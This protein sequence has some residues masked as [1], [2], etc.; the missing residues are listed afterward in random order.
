MSKTKIQIFDPPMCCSTGICGPTI[1]PVLIQVNEM[2][3]KLK[4]EYADQVEMERHMFGQSIAAFQSSPPVTELIKNQGA[5]VLPITTV[6]GRIIK[7]GG[8]PSMAEL[9]VYL[10]KDS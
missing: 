7:S 9:L 5:K 10:K 3:Q 4:K 2:V 8:Y 1:D 6:D